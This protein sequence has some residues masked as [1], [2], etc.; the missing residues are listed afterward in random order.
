MK[1]TRFKPEP[2]Q[3][4]GLHDCH[5]N[6]INVSDG[7]IMLTV[8]DV[9]YTINGPDVRGNIIVENVDPDFCEVIIQGKGGK[10]GGFRGEKLTIPEFTEKYKG[11]SF[12][13]IDEYYGWRKLQ[14]AGWL[15]M[16]DS[17]PKDMT[18]SIS[19]FKGDIVYNT[20]EVA[21]E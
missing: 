16:P 14:F 12:E 17:Y 11:F 19:Y 7:N 4:F 6:G 5:I 13:V 9:F 3:P 8:K 18:L 15:W 20:E 21:R 1:E 2:K 10:M